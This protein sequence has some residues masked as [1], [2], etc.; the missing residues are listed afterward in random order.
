MSSRQ[1]LEHIAEG[2]M[3]WSA[4]LNVKPMSEEQFRRI[5]FVAL[6]DLCLALRD[7]PPH[8]SQGGDT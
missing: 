8:P 4:S 5:V 7:D 6:A 1:Q 2:L 3:D